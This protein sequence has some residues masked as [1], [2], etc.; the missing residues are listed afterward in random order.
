[1]QD[2][3][4]WKAREPY[5]LKLNA[6]KEIDMRCGLTWLACGIFFLCLTTAIASPAQT[7]TRLHIFIG[8]EGANPYARLLQ[9]TDG[10]LYGTTAYGGV[11]GLGAVFKITPRGKLTRLYSFAGK[12]GA[13]PYAGLVQATNGNLYGTTINGGTHGFGTVFKI[14]PRG[15]LTRLYSFAG[16]DGANPW[17]ELLQATNGNLYGTTFGGGKNGDG[18]VF[19]ITPSGRLTTVHNFCSQSNCA[20][21]TNPVAGLVQ[22][23]DG[24]LYGTT[25][26]GGLDYWDGGFGTVFKIAP[27]GDLTTLYSFAGKDGTNPE[28]GLV[29]A[30][31]GNLYGTT[32]LGGANG[33]Y[34]TV[35]KI[36]PR[37]ELT[38]LHSFAGK[39]GANPY[40]GLVQATNGNLYGTTLRGGYGHGTVFSL[41]VSA[42]EQAG[43]K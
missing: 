39:D 31:N 25:L 4:E 38:T 22:A 13:N 42:R 10:N 6:K 11:H 14:T 24:N 28:A 20:D 26:L 8:T 19:K 27:N 36:T 29:Q 2:F 15:K 21:G 7:F 16:K 5:S 17:A 12:D 34:G 43:L 33:D 30:T 41:S 9:A 18:T 35:F 37:G 40:A 23:T 3:R 32:L 1:V